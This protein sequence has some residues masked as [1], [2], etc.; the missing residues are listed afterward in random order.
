[1]RKY[2]SLLVVSAKIQDKP[3]LKNYNKVELEIK[4]KSLKPIAQGGSAH[5][6]A[7]KTAITSVNGVILKKKV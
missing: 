3:D 1:M 5:I 4:E 7:I 6:Y 2:K